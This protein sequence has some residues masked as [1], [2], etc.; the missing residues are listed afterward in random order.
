MIKCH[1]CQRTCRKVVPNQ[2]EFDRTPYWRCD[3]HGSTVVRQYYISV[4]AEP[5]C[6]SHIGLIT[7]YKDLQYG[8]YLF[9]DE[10]HFPHKFRID[11]INPYP[12]TTQT[13]MTL[14]FHP[15]IT[16]ENVQQKL[17]TYIMFS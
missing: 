12:R 2:K 5:L 16:P 13:V 7:Y 1:F 3:Y 4:Q 10:A 9:F 17:P 15:D 14:D 6:I 11:K 8:A